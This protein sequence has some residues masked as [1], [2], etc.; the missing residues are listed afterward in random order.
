MTQ[1]YYGTTAGSTQKNPPSLIYA[2]IGGQVPTPGDLTT[3]AM[4]AKVWFY[5]ST[6]APADMVVTANPG[7]IVD[8]VRLG[9]TNGDI[10]LG[11]VNG[12]GATTDCYPY[13]GILYSSQTSL[14]TGGFA[15]TSNYTT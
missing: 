11:V 9:M 7:G 13:I 15:I 10:L 2:V 6:N 3:K 12:G 8:G 4:G 14:T 5:S 1:T